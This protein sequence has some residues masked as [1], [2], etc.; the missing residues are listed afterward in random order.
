MGSSSKCHCLLDQSPVGFLMVLYT[1]TLIIS[2]VIV[3][4]YEPIE[5]PEPPKE[6]EPEP[7]KEEEKKGESSKEGILLQ[8]YYLV[9]CDM[10]QI[11]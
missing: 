3:A 1:G 6:P 11:Y 8:Y 7:P 9:Y 4:G 2:H 5:I 10:I